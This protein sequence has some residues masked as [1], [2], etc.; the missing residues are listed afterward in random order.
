MNKT[1]LSTALGLVLGVTS[2]AAYA[3]TVNSENTLTINPG[4]VPIVGTPNPGITGSWF[5][6]DINFNGM[7]DSSEMNVLSQGMVGL[8]IGITTLPG[9]SHSGVPVAGDTNTIDAP[10]NFFGNTGS[11]Y[12]TVPV[13]GSTSSGASAGGLDLSGWTM[14]WNGNVIPLGSGA[15][16]PLNCSMLGCSGHTFTNGNAEFTWDGVWGDP[17]SLNYAATTPA[18]SIFGVVKYYLHLE[19]VVT[20]IPVP[21]PAAGWLLIS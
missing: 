5:A 18:G 15:W 19:G 7:I 17:Y 11:D 9:A 13:S 2:A 21:L 10:Y 14:A 8:P 12:L 16:Q 3:A 4:V 20:P 6:M 1:A